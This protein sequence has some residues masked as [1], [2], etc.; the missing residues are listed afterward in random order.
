L[1]AVLVLNAFDLWALASNNESYESLIYPDF[2]RN[3]E[4]RG[5]RLGWSLRCLLLGHIHVLSLGMQEHVRLNCCS[6][7]FVWS[8]QNH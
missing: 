4:P 5:H 2:L 6:L 8:S 7:K 1:N 3:R